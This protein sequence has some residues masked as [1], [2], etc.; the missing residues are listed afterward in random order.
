MNIHL[1]ILFYINFICVSIVLCS[2]IAHSAF[3]IESDPSSAIAT[4]YVSVAAY[5]GLL[6]CRI[7]TL[8]C[9]LHTTFKDTVHRMS[10]HL[11]IIFVVLFAIMVLLCI[12]S[13]AISPFVSEWYHDWPLLIVAAILYF[14]TATYACA[15]FARNLLKMAK[16]RAKSPINALGGQIQRTLTLNPSQ[17]R[18]VDMT[19]KYVLLFI[20]SSFSTFVALIILL[21]EVIPDLGIQV[22]MVVAGIDGF[23]GHSCIF[24][25]YAFAAKLYNRLCGRLD[26]MLK[27]IVGQRMLKIMVDPIE[28]SNNAYS[29]FPAEE[30]EQSDETADLNS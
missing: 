29:G 18:Y 21:L 10:H 4:I 30:S 1:K 7:G 13:M 26:K 27:V 24:L 11:R 9:R 6:L 25:Q 15:R 28:S 2:N 14:V 17:L 3:C 8:L 19:S 22:T 16:S 23:V 20:V 12:I 5:M